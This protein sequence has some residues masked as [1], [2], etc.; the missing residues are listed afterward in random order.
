MNSSL[1]ELSET[2][3][4]VEKVWFTVIIVL[5]TDCFNFLLWFLDFVWLDAFMS[6]FYLIKVD[7]L[8]RNKLVLLW[9]IKLNCKKEKRV[10]LL[11]VILFLYLY[12]IMFKKIL[13]DNSWI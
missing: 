10:I 9:I 2:G 4:V 3:L 12:I 7:Y 11:L 13:L 6:S 8:I 5:S 1:I